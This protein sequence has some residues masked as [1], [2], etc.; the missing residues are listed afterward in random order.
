[1]FELQSAAKGELTMRQLQSVLFLIAAGLVT[2]AGTSYVARA[3]AAAATS[4]TILKASDITPQMFPERVFYQGKTAPTEMRN[5][6]GVRF[7]DGAYFLAGLVDSSGYS[8]AV[9]S[10][11]QAYLLTEVPLRFG[12][13]S[14]S[15]VKAGAYGAGFVSG[16]FVVTDLGA[17]ELVRVPSHHDTAIKRPIPLQIVAGPT[18]GTYR[19]YRGRDY[20]EFRRG[21]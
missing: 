9:K 8:T 21:N 7:A 3:G 14:G 2:A 12:D 16:F 18:D 13:E 10:K 4:S 20:V 6:G 19:L 5:T 15:E 1:M 11:Y 17:H